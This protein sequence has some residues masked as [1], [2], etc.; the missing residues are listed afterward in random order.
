MN[1]GTAYFMIALLL[2]GVPIGF[3]YMM[4]VNRQLRADLDAQSVL[5]VER[6]ARIEELTTQLAERDVI[7]AARDARIVEITEQRD[8][9][10][11]AWN[12]ASVRPSGTEPVRSSAPAL[13]LMGATVVPAALGAYGL[14]KRR[15]H[16]QSLQASEFDELLET[17]RGLWKQFE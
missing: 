7:I 4:S 3:G 11:A 15:A 8:A 14:R 12:T 9:L 2:A 13:V 17:R 5:I 10:Q 6:D 16:Q 1:K